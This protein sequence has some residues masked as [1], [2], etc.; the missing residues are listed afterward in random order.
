MLASDALCMFLCGTPAIDSCIADACVADRL[1]WPRL[2]VGVM[3]T[4]T[5]MAMHQVCVM[6]VALS[7]PNVPTATELTHSTLIQYGV[8][9]VEYLRGMASIQRD[10]LT[11]DAIRLMMLPICQTDFY[12]MQKCVWLVDSEHTTWVSF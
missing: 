2:L 12:G 10:W 11:D 4:H 5:W 1:S 3:N 9:Q 6:L 8:T 7:R